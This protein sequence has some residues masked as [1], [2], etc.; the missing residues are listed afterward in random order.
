MEKKKEMERRMIGERSNELVA[1]RLKREVF[2]DSEVW[3]CTKGDVRD[4]IKKRESVD[5]GRNGQRK[6]VSV[7]NTYN[8][9]TKSDRNS[10]HNIDHIKDTLNQ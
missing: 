10:I 3:K 4:V 8:M 7:S 5:N 2:V 1:K 6:S 9:N